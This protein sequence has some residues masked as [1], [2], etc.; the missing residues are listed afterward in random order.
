[1]WKKLAKN[2]VREPLVNLI[3][4]MNTDIEAS[5][6]VKIKGILSI[7]LRIEARR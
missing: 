7:D 3:V 2:G 6:S 1:M 5:T 4:K